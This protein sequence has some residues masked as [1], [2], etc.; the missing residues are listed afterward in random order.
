MYTAA[1]PKKPKIPPI[2]F[3]RLDN[4]EPSPTFVP[5]N[6]KCKNCGSTVL[7]YYACVEDAKCDECPQWQNEE[8]IQY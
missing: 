1:A 7:T 4:G 5:G 8:L 6:C 3:L 2:Q